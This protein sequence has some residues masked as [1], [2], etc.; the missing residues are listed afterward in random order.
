MYSGE[1]PKEIKFHSSYLDI[2]MFCKNNDNETLRVEWLKWDLD[3]NQ[4]FLYK[5]M[6]QVSFFFHYRYVNMHC[7]KILNYWDYKMR[8]VYACNIL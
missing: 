1:L 2:C 5:I 4:W 3:I 7:V 8:R 6:Q